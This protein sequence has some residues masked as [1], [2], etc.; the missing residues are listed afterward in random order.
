MTNRAN[1]LI[2]DLRRIYADTRENIRT[3]NE[4]KP[5]RRR[6]ALLVIYVGA[7][8]GLLAFWKGVG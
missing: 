7:V 2:T 6:H 3:I 4:A 5:K 8:V 1:D